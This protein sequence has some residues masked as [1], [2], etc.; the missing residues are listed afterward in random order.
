VQVGNT[1]LYHANSCQSFF[2]SILIWLL[3]HWDE[4]FQLCI[5]LFVD[6]ARIEINHNFAR[7]YWKSCKLNLSSWQLDVVMDKEGIQGRNCICEVLF[8]M[9][10]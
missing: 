6:Y 4:K 9:Y 8:F 5:A 2:S 10:R 3:G 1:I 7:L